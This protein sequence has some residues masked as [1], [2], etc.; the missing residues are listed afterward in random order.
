MNDRQK[1]LLIVNRGLR[2]GLSFREACKRTGVAESTARG[3]RKRED[4]PE[5]VEVSGEGKVSRK[6]MSR[7]AFIIASSRG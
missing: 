3:W 6:V 4:M 7:L 2:N 5:L 1:K